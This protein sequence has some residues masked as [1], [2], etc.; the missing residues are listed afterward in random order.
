MQFDKSV[1]VEGFIAETNEHI[2][3]INDCVISLRND[4][5]NSDMIASVLRELH[6][7]KGTSRMMGYPS[8]EQLAHG[9]EDVFKGIQQGKYKLNDQIVQLSFL[10]G[11]CVRRGLSHI[12]EDGTDDVDVSAFL[13][14]FAK[15]AAGE[16]FSTDM[17]EDRNNQETAAGES[18][19]ENET[20]TRSLGNITTIR[21]SIERINMIIQS[22]DNLITRQFRLK[23]Q[24]EELKLFEQSLGSGDK[25]TGIT[26]IKHSVRRIRKQIEEDL[27]LMENS[28]LN[29]QHLVLDLRMLPL[30]MLFSPLKK[31]IESEALALG[32]DVTFDIPQTDSMLDKI[33][34]EQLN[35]VLLHLVRNSIDHG[36]E[37]PEERRALG[38]NPQGL[39]S[40][41]TRQIAS[42]V[43]ITVA[44]DGNGIRYDKV[45]DKAAGMFPEQAKAIAEMDE[46]GLQ[47]YLFLSGFSTREETTAL[48]GRGVGLDIVRTSM[49]KIKGK[50]RLRS[51]LHEGTEFE[52]TIPLSLATQQGLFV[53]AGER[54]FLIP[55][56]YI[57]EITA[58]SAER[59]IDMQNQTVITVHDQLIPVYYLSSIL[60]GA[61]TETAS[62]VIVVEY[63]EKQLAVVVDRIE[64]YV[65]VVVK[66]LPPLMRD[67]GA[68][69]GIVFDENYAIIPILHIPEIMSRLRTLPAYDIKKYEA[70]NERRIYTVLVV[71]DSNTT[72]QIEKTIFEASGYQVETAVDGIDA[73]DKMR[74]RHMDAVVTDIKMPRMDGLVLVNNIRRLEEYADTPVIIVSAVYDPEVKAQFMDAGV[75]AF[76]VK[77]DFQRGNLVQAVKELLGEEY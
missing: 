1:L 4:A 36:I 41:H 11:D 57:T 34:L 6:T 47:Q 16:L 3:T 66:P 42:Y 22:F 19:G 54:K 24:L 72:R 62:S 13:K 77:S 32:K 10:T 69:E 64:Q 55:S 8:L 50:I 59:F 40:V 48:S 56:H 65:N 37:S 73:L 53:Y 18:S 15:A 33:I 71:D 30:D 74:A 51:K 12:H 63:L 14:V 2:D 28:V 23:H 49:E 9:L 70:K 39:I 20:D 67:F 61:K 7:V 29:T 25:N 21:V 26:G 17:I 75:Q 31:T 58:V 52:L 46:R 27:S 68:L 38:K 5:G 60:G 45:R 76:I 35:D 43:V 44:D